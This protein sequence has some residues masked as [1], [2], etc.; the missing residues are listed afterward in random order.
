[1]QEAFI[2]LWLEL[3][4][5]KSEILERY[6]SGVYF[7]D[8]VYGLRA[9]ARHFFDKPPEALT[10][11]EAALLAASVKAPSRLNPAD[12]PKGAAARARLVAAAMLETGAITPEQARDCCRAK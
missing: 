5:S 6:L 3:R 12:N 2:A 7:G 4:L 11:S 10:V 8:G 9:A 1:F